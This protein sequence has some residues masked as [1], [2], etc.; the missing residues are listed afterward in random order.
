MRTHNAV[1][2]AFSFSSQRAAAAAAAAANLL[3]VVSLH[4]ICRLA[5]LQLLGEESEKRFALTI[6]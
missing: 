3:T 2:S 1:I 6:R 5:V 4:T